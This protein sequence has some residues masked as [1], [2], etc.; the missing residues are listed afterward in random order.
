MYKHYI[1]LF[2]IIFLTLGC[3][4]SYECF[5]EYNVEGKRAF[6]EPDS[7]VETNGSCKYF[8]REG[9]WVND[10]TVLTDIVY[11]R[12]GRKV[13][14]NAQGTE[15]SKNSYKPIEA[16]EFILFDFDLK[17]GQ[18]SSQFFPSY[19]LSDIYL[20]E[21]LGTVYLFKFY[22]VYKPFNSDEED[23]YLDANIF[24]SEKYGV[25]GSYFTEDS[26]PS[27]LIAPI[28]EI[29]EKEIDYS[30]KEVRRLL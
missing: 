21:S 8:I 7:L 14:A 18:S 2:S 3:T 22:Q 11:Y 20:T 27:F 19:Y 9:I 1:L 30:D 29:L 25:V 6:F 23:W 13:Y 15:F 26:E 17:V 4:Q 12:I 5:E 24:V 10:S 16:Q 28:G